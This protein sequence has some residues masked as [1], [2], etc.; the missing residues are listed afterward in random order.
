MLRRNN[1]RVPSSSILSEG[2]SD[3]RSRS[4]PTDDEDEDEYEG[5]DGYDESMQLGES[6]GNFGRA[7]SPSFRGFTAINSAAEQSNVRSS[8]LGGQP[9]PSKQWKL[10]RSPG[11]KSITLRSRQL[12]RNGKADMIPKIARDLANRSQPASLT[13][14]DDMILHTEDIMV[15]LHQQVE[16]AQEGD[17]IQG[18]L[19]VRSLELMRIWNSHGPPEQNLGE[20]IGPGSGATSLQNATY[21]SSLLLALRHPPLLYPSVG[22]T[23][24]ALGSKALTASARPMPIP[25]VMVDWLNRYHLSY[26]DLLDVVRSTRPNCTAHEQFW[27]LVFGML[28]RGQISHVIQLFSEADFQHAASALE[29]GEDE[30]GYRGTQLQAVQSAAHRAR[31]LLKGCPATNGDW[32]IDNS[33]WDLFRKKASSNLNHLAK[34]GDFDEGEDQVPD[35][36]QAEHFGLRKT[37]RL[38]PQSTQTGQSRLPWSIYQKLKVLYGILIGSADE[39]IAQSQ[40][41]LE[42][43][44]ALTIWWDGTEDMNIASWSMNVSRAQSRGDLELTEDPFLARISAGFLCVTDPEYED[45]F[46]INPLSPL[47]V[48]LAS[49]LQG[50]LEGVLG[51][52]RTYSLTIASTVA[53]IGGLAGWLDPPRTNNACGL[54]QEDLMVLSY[55]A[56]SQ[57]ITKND[58]LLYYAKQLF[59]RH[60]FVGEGDVREGWEL[61]ISVTSRVDDPQLAAETIRKFLDQMH[62]DSQDRLDKL[63][64]LCSSLG[65]EA[66]ARKVAERFADHLGANTTLYG[67]ALVCYARAHAPAKIRQLVDLLISYSLIQSA[68]Y[69]PNS[70]LDDELRI[71][72]ESPK[73]PLSKLNQVDAGAAEMLQFYLAG[74]ACLRRFYNLRD[75]EVIAKAEGRTANMK[76]LARKR[77]A[78]KA[79]MAVINSSADCIYGGLYDAERE[80]AIQVDGLLVLL[81]EVTAFVMGG[82]GGQQGRMQTPTL[83]SA[84]MYDVLAA[85]EH[86]QTVNERVYE[87]TEDCLAASMRNFLQGSAPPS[88]RAML[89]KSVS[90]G[91]AGSGFSFSMIGSEMLSGGDDRGGKSIGSSGVLVQAKVERAWDWRSGFGEREKEGGGGEGVRGADVLAHLR[92]AIAA[93]LVVAELE[94]WG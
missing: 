20:G 49:I 34:T 66:E 23:G 19:A 31:E 13:E 80:S 9:N 2:I 12:P 86:L 30:P 91:T 28:V 5:G 73:R 87:A 37:G 6:A 21:L 58:L 90:S 76:P 72:V 75:E 18:L 56:D 40:D 79:L 77:A 93:D 51:S 41:W 88:P 67:P 48:G 14:P 54:D 38:L 4:H 57:G 3:D 74:Y 22:A 29:D 24:R 60:E 63:I 44:A 10:Q 43:T 78:A 33:D 11:S 62:L 55:G 71:L 50:N 45:S 15:E 94:E 59:E 35:T 82:R 39:V 46:Q 8:L 89:K 42:A 52:L 7:G 69:P 65:L 64:A 83:T 32:Q 68:A 61:A 70:D 92:R 27:D 16:N 85:I 81:G 1:S 36:F 47:E 84:Q 53:E 26:D 17:A 25:K